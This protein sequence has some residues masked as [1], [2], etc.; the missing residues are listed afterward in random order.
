MMFSS[1]QELQVASFDNQST[2][3]TTLKTTK[4]STSYRNLFSKDKPKINPKPLKSIPSSKD[5]FAAL[6]SREN[7]LQIR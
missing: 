5:L 3:S 2:F 6:N 1:K 7:D 4:R